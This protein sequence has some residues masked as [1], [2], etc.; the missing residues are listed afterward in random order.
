MPVIEY[1]SIDST[2]LT[3]Y[4][5]ELS[6]GQRQRIAIART[7]AMEPE[8]ILLDEPT[9]SLDKELIDSVVMLVNLLKQKGKTIVVVTHDINFAEKVGDKIINFNDLYIKIA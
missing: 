2:L 9:A 1:L 7:L 5:P 8:I 3:K 6:R 4:P